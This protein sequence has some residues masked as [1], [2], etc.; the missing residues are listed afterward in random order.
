MSLF[1]LDL[2]WTAVS[3]KEKTSSGKIN[4][5]FK[6]SNVIILVLLLS[7]A[8]SVSLIFKLNTELKTYSSEAFDYEELK[9]EVNSCQ[10]QIRNTDADLRSIK[11][12]LQDLR[13]LRSDLAD[14]FVRIIA[15]QDLNIRLDIAKEQ[16]AIL[17][18]METELVSIEDS[19][20]YNLNTGLDYCRFISVP[21]DS[22]WSAS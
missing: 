18:Q 20:D 12:D 10:N 16:E 9:I 11:T 8:W 7:L 19:V 15:F 21:N 6:L 14:D 4:S 5:L 2:E 13:A 3:S 22:V 17:K 1:L